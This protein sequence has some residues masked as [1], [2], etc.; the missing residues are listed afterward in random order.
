MK[1]SCSIYLLG[2]FF[3]FQAQKDIHPIKK[4]SEAIEDN[5]FFIEEAY[6]QA[7]LVA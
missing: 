7:T 4:F 3:P 1:N 6:S 2:H 5:S